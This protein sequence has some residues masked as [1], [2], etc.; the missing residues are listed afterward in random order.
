M[1]KSGNEKLERP[2]YCRSESLVAQTVDACGYQ[3]C[4]VIEYGHLWPLTHLRLPPREVEDCLERM[5]LPG[6]FGSSITVKIR[7]LVSPILPN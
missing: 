7:W 5:F 3:S 2:F 4:G 6:S 1:Q